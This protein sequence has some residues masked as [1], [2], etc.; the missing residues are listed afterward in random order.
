MPLPAPGDLPNP[1]IK[2]WSPASQADSL[3]TELQGKPH[4]EPPPPP[5]MSL[6]AMLPSPLANVILQEAP[7]STG[8]SRQEYWSGLPFPPPGI[9]LTQGSNLRSLHCRQIPYHLSH[10]GSPNEV[11]LR[12]KEYRL[13]GLFF[14]WSSSKHI[15]MVMEQCSR[16]VGIKTRR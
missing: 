11:V 14:S 7:L 13:F 3:P 4:R 16:V 5:P 8:V 1:G 6:G 9:I 10:Q 15:C 12:T 2:P